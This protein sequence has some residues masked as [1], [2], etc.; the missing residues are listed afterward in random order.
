VTYETQSSF[1]VPERPGH[2]GLHQAAVDLA[3]RASGFVLEYD[4]EHAAGGFFQHHH[5]AGRSVEPVHDPAA[6]FVQQRL[7]DASSG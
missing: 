4:V 5:A 2:R 1:V 3:Q 6:G 7:R